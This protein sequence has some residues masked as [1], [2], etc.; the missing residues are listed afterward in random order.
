VL[1]LVVGTVVVIHPSNF[2]WRNG[3]IAAKVPPGVTEPTGDHLQTAFF[4]WLWQHAA[5]TL[6][7]SPFHDLFQ[8]GAL[9]Q[10]TYQPFGWP[11]VL[12]S[13]PVGLLAGPAAAYNTIVV[14]A[15]IA[16]GV[17]TYALI[18]QLG[19]SRLAAAVAG[20]AFAFAPVRVLQGTDH[21]NALLAP[22]LPLLILFLERALHGE[23]WGRWAAVVCFVSIV[24]SGELLLAVYAAGAVAGWLVLRWPAAPARHRLALVAPGIFAAVLAGDI[25]VIIHHA[26]L[27]PSGAGGGRSA[28]EAATYAPRLINL[29][30]WRPSATVTGE[31]YFYL[32][33]PIAILAL[34]GAV[35]ASRSREHRRMA[36]GLVAGA[37]VCVFFAVAPGVTAHPAVQHL[38][39]ALP[40]FGYI[41]T[42]GRIYVLV[43]LILAIL[44]AWGVDLFPHGWLRVTVA[45]VAMSG[46]V[47]TTP[48]GRY[49]KNPLPVR[50]TAVPPAARLLHLPPFLPGDADNATYTFSITQR[51]VPIANGYTPFA[52][53]ALDRVLAQLGGMTAVPPDPCQW[54]VLT[55]RYDIDYVAVHIN[56]FDRTAASWHTTGAR[57]VAALD[58]TVWLARVEQ[59]RDVVVYRVDRRRVSCP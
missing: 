53:P 52:P 48:P 11:L 31:R 29:V 3:F 23:R 42:P 32:G 26:V 46:I 44:A 27:A 17:I 35:A 51:P 25:A 19:R 6:T 56:L 57:L 40:F 4:L 50:L 22:L 20:F 30:Q 36:A 18:R 7:N 59:A 33:V 12:V 28:A 58:K 16:C 5:R 15:F 1:L 8:F 2:A 21:L 45:A 49:G 55:E 38:G 24:A 34:I 41:R 14:L 43:A 9:G 39:R 47:A 13:V 54:K 37:I 10:T